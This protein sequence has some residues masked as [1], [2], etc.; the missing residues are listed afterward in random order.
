[1]AWN[2]AENRVASQIVFRWM[3]LHGEQDRRRSKM[4]DVNDA[5]EG[6]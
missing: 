5:S 4:S 3:V 6:M 1:M 2:C